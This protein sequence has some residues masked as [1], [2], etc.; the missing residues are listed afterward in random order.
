MDT[1]ALTSDASAG[2]ARI[3][4]AMLDAQLAGLVEAIGCPGF[5][6]A[7]LGRVNAAARVDF[8]SAYR[9]YAAQPPRMF[10]SASLADKDVSGDCFKSYRAG[11]YRHDRTLTGARDLARP[12][13][14]AMTRWNE[15]EI[16]S[17]HRD[18]I[19][20]RHDIC[21]RLS[22]VSGEA[23]GGF[24]AINFYRNSHSGHYLDGDVDVVQSLARSLMAAVCKHVQLTNGA[25]SA[26]SGSQESLARRLGERCPALTSRELDVCVRLLRGWTY[27][28]IA[29]DLGVSVPSVKTYRARAFDRLGIHFRSELF[30][31][32]LDLG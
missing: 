29:A 28:G 23:D 19:Y 16:P 1:W 5:P 13:S 20:R 3:S 18:R 27:E 14:P 17:P 31:L 6:E 26:G 11:L 7:V 4:A 9:V 8:W 32:A 15:A 10:M 25:K 2:N 22:V 30:G 24:L 12:G 21:E